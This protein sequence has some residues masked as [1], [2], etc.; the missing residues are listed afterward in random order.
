MSFSGRRLSI[1]R[2][3][4][5]RFSVGK[6]LSE[7]GTLFIYT[8]VFLLFFSSSQEVMFPALLLLHKLPLHAAM[9]L[10]LV[11]E[12]HIILRFLQQHKL[13][14]EDYYMHSN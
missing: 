14:V 4:N 7:N 8:Y 6:E 9:L 1:L 3:S 2:P 11:H 5:R 13:L 12:G 10:S